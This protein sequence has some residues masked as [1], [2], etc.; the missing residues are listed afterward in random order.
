MFVV[1]VMAQLYVFGEQG[2]DG[3][4]GR[5]GRSVLH[6]CE[7][8]VALA[9]ALVGR[10]VWGSIIIRLCALTVRF[11]KDLDETIH[12]YAEAL[13]FLEKNG[14]TSNETSSLHSAGQFVEDWALEVAKDLDGA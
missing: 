3:K 8:L 1:L 6:L 12:D 11:D 9:M 2:Q 10:S 14:L 5:H 13:F 4:Q 7:E